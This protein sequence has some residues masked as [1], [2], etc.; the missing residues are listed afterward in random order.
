MK[1]DKTAEEL[2]EM[3]C[4]GDSIKEIS[5]K[6]G[7]PFYDLRRK[8]DGLRIVFGAR[9]ITHLVHLYTKETIKCVE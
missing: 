5:V 7:K 9:S 1:L 3:L 8:I 6:T 2:L 4:K